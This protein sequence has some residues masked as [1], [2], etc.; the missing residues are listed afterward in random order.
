MAE[1]AKFFTCVF[2]GG[3]ATDFGPQIYSGPG[4]DGV[5]HIPFFVDAKNC[6]Y[7]LDGGPHKMPG[8]TA[9]NSSVIGSS[10]TKIQAL[11]DYWRQGTGG[12][13]TQKR[14][15]YAG[16]QIFKDEIGRASCRERV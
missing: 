6:V 3:W 15:V 5:M 8:T 4:Q 11:Y 10:S 2:D 13:P 9:L 14:V 1:Q 16:T 12:S 7:E